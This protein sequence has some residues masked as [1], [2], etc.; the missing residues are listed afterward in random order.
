M[1]KEENSFNNAQFEVIYSNVAGI[2][3]YV[4]ICMRDGTEISNFS[5]VINIISCPLFIVFVDTDK[6]LLIVIKYY[7]QSVSD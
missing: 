6:S 3:V 1:L 2:H 5:L 4:A 7:Q